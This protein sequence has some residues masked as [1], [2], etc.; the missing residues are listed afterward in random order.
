MTDDFIQELNQDHAV[1]MLG[2]KCFILN[3]VVEP[4]FNRPDVTFSSVHDFRTKY[5]NCF[6]IEQNSRGKETKVPIAEI[7]LRSP[8]RREFEGVVFSPGGDVAGY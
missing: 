1:V 7:W 6:K 8:D 2:G 4:I 5:A 3:E